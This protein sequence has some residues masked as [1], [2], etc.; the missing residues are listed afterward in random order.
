MRGP[1]TIDTPFSDKPVKNTQ[2]EPLSACTSIVRR[3]DGEWFEIRCNHCGANC[4]PVRDT[5]IKGVNGLQ[6]HLRAAHGLSVTAQEAV[7]ESV[8]R[9]LE[10]QEV[11]DIVA[12]KVT[13]EK[14]YTRSKPQRTAHMSAP[15][16]GSADAIDELPWKETQGKRKRMPESDAHVKSKH[17]KG[18]YPK[19]KPVKEQSTDLSPDNQ[20]RLKQFR[21]THT[22]VDYSDDLSIPGQP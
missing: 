15:T 2:F 10:A 4:D 20:E 16:N 17:P 14:V 8:H 19:D 13:I 11:D 9:T 7:D 3:T 22:L 18:I 6:R 12:G 21:A 5:Y 1:G